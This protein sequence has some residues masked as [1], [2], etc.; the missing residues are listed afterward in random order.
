MARNN[1]MEIKPKIETIARIKVVGVGGSGHNAIHRMI[2]AGLTGVEFIA[3]NSD[4]QSLHHSKADRK[5][6]IGKQ[7][8][9]GLGAGM[10]AETLEAIKG[11]DMVFVTCG[12][13][14]GTGSGAGP[15]VAD[16]AK[17]EGILTVAVVT[18]P[19]AFEGAKRREIAEKA[20]EE[21]KESVDTIIVIPNDRI[22]QIID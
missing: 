17:E 5:V 2:T 16:L 14:G 12:L 20:L 13:G 22:L 8:T 11:A 6:Q 15:V 21:F 19:F 18:K 7:T 1:H 3:I 10:K 4:A 9:R